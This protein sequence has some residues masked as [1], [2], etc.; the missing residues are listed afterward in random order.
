M[1]DLAKKQS[2][3]VESTIKPA[4][5]F[6]KKIQPEDKTVIACGHDN[7][8]MCSAVVMQR[9]LRD[10][11]D[12]DAE[13]FVTKDNFALTDE[14]VDEIAKTGAK[15]I[16]VVDIAHVDYSDHVKKVLSTNNS[17][18]IDHH[19]PIK[20]SGIVYCNPRVFEKKIYMPVSY[21][22]YKIYEDLGDPS[23]VAWVAGVGVLSDHAVAI[24]GDLFEKIKSLDSRLIGKT[25]LKEEDLFSYSVIG[26]LAKI[27][28]SARVVG[29][30]VGSVLAVR[31][32]SKAKS[33]QEIM[34]ASGGDAAKLMAWSELVRKEFKKLVTDFNKKRK[35]L[36]GKIIFYEIPSKLFIKSSLAGYLVQ[37]YPENVLVVAQKIGESFDVSFR[38]GDNAKIDLNKMA[39]NAIVGIPNAEGG[40]HEAASGARIPIKFMPKFLKQL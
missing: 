40:G 26:A 15:N 39:K 16:V 22:T 19:Q 23:D 33:Y 38:R 37:F 2:S 8:S 10:F 28:D 32:L 6:L 21:I 7:D 5:E 17:L 14:D 27:L 20:L 12:N 4:L 34:N 3:V 31:A 24:A 35:L 25:N 36:K 1:I 30:R 9:T 18:V 11:S 13:I 29:G